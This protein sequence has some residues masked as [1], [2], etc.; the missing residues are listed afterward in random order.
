MDKPLTPEFIALTVPTEAEERH[1]FLKKF[2]QAY[3][4]L[5]AGEAELARHADLPVPVAFRNAGFL[6]RWTRLLNHSAPAAVPWIG[7]TRKTMTRLILAMADAL[8]TP[9]LEIAADVNMPLPDDAPLVPADFLIAHAA[10]IAFEARH[11]AIIVPTPE[12]GALLAHADIGD[13]IQAGMLKPPFPA[14]YVPFGASLAKF[15]CDLYQRGD[16]SGCFCFEAFPD[17]DKPGLRT[18]SIHLLTG[19]TPTSAIAAT[20]FDLEIDDESLCL[21]QVLETAMASYH[22]ADGQSSDVDC[23]HGVF[24]QVAFLAKLFIYMG[25]KAAQLTPEPRHTE[26]LQ[27]LAEVKPG[28]RA[29]KMRQLNRLY[30]RVIVG[31]ATEHARAATTLHHE[32]GKEIAAHWRRGHFRS[33]RHGPALTLVKI[34]FIAPVLVRADRLGEGPISPTPYSIH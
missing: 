22:M 10:S 6:A 4:H 17:Q 25:I 3:E 26:A 32:S 16:V 8:Q 21:K 29:K 5:H 1:R 7:D 23:R 30:D 28:K 13:D 19:L 14:I 12:L 18:I 24:Q 33:Q 2:V 31:P 11:G 20:H 9:A 34:I 27:R 15:F